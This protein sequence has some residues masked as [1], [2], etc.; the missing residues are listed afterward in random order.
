M[1][2][3]TTTNIVD[4]QS[5]MELDDYYYRFIKYFS[6]FLHPITYLQQNKYK[7]IWMDKCEENFQNMKQ[8]LST[9]PILKSKIPM[10]VLWF[11]QM[12]AKKYE[13]YT[14][15]MIM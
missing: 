6:K 3:A 11:A 14:C 13:E 12:H 1:E 10:E 15:E 4:I 5:F 2:K 9:T 7:F 8:L